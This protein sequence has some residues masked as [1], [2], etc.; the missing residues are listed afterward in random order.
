MSFTTCLSDIRGLSEG[1]GNGKFVNLRG[2]NSP[3][4]LARV[5][6]LKRAVIQNSTLRVQGRISKVVGTLV[7]TSGISAG[8]GDLCRLR[9]CRGRD[10]L[11][12]VVGFQDQKLL[13]MPMEGIQEL[14]P[15][16]PVE[17]LE[18]GFQV[19][20]SEALLGRVVDG[21]GRP[22][23]GRGELDP[24]STTE[25]SLDADPPP[26]LARPPVEKVFATGVRALDSLLTIGCGQRVGLFAGSGVG[27]STLMGML[28]RVSGADVNV[29]AL[30]GERGREVGDFV[31]SQLGESGMANSVV[32]AATSDRSPLERVKAAMLATSLAE[33]FRDQGRDVCLMMDSV[34]RVA[35]AQREIGLA[36]GEPPTSR[37]YTPSVFSLLPRLLE[38]AGPS[39]RGTI[40]GIYTVLVEGDDL[41][42][43]IA[44]TARG[45]LDG[46]VVLSRKLAERNHYPAIDVLASVSRIMGDLVTRE[47]V[48]RAGLLRGLLADLTEA[49]EL[50]SI[51]GYQPGASQSL[52]RAFHWE[53]PLLEFLQQ[54]S[55]QSVAWDESVQ[56]LQSLTDQVSAYSPTLHSEMPLTIGDNLRY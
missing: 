5:R 10:L 39:P 12:E 42:D 1:I 4:P 15:G 11:A 21:L 44:D 22:I 14:S 43:P 6:E 30:V 48:D 45:I 25:L 7:E 16:A 36:V 2:R 38:R 41:N 50:M 35:M 53:G 33:G 29:I 24:E 19:P 23:D 34:T 28:A 40:T 9:T 26:A 49:Q 54:R 55:H 37:G 27:K 46:H 8:V 51:G 3:D 17:R 32:V 13:L 31:R 20:F 52:D 56:S 18:K 47:H